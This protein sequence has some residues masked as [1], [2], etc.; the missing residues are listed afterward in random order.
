MTPLFTA[1]Y[2]AYDNDAPLKAALEGGL[3]LESAPPGTSY[4]YGIFT[5]V[6]R[7]PLNMLMET[8]EAVTVQ[9]SVFSDES[10]AADVCA[11]FETLD[12]VYNAGELAIA[13]Y[14]LVSMLR[15]HDSLEMIR[16]EGIWRYS[17]RYRIVMRTTT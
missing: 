1:V 12:D 8:W 4:P 7:E 17:A 10:S 16:P 14:A 13:G 15:E 11:V 5:L 2:E 6:S 9:F 3:F